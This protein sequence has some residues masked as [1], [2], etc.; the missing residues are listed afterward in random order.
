M[1]SAWLPETV[2]RFLAQLPAAA[3]ESASSPWGDLPENAWK[4]GLGYV[5]IVA[6]GVAVNIALFFRFLR[7]PIPWRERVHGLEQRPWSA[8]EAV[9]LLVFLVLLYVLASV[10][11]TASGDAGE[12]AMG[13]IVLQSAMFHLAGVGYIFAAL[14]RQGLSWAQAFGFDARRAA[15]HV[16][17]GVVIY[18]AMMPVLWFY[19]AIYQVGLKAAGYD[20]LPQEVVLLFTSEESLWA[21]AY[22]LLLAAAIAPLF[23]ELLFRGIAL[24]VLARRRGVA[25]SVI[26][27]SAFFAAI[28][29]HLPSLVPLFVVAVFLCVGYIYS[30]SLL[31]PI[32]MHG[33]FNV[34]NLAFL[35]LLKSGA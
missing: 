12:P 26:V 1:M 30:G 24:P 31:V 35:A 11:R 14:R 28:H 27:V 19:S 6:V 29:F 32:V 8:S 25:W 21:R 23:E 15:G 17:T 22:M 13:W 10:A 18:L 4:V 7:R 16:G 9:R 34:V 2:L 33:I 3:A 5:A 20:V